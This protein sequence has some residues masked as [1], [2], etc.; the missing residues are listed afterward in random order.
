MRPPRFARRGFTLIEL[1]VVIAIIAVLIG[2][3]LPAVQRAREAA[4]RS[5][6]QNNLKQIGLAL[7]MYHD[8]RG[9]F[10][11]AYLHEPS[12]TKLAARDGILG[13]GL[14]GRLP[15]PPLALL[16]RAGLDWWAQLLTPLEEGTPAPG[17]TGVVPVK[18]DRPPPPPPGDPQ[19]PGWGWCALLLPFVEQ[20]VLADQINFTIPVEAPSSLAARTTP[21]AVY[22]CP[23]DTKAGLFDVLSY[24]QNKVLGRAMT[25]SYTANYGAL[26]LLTAHPDAGTGLMFRNS[27]VR[28]ADVTDG[29]SNTLAVGERPGT[30]TQTPWAGVFSGGSARTTPGAPVYRAII[31]PSPAMAMAR[32]G[33]RPLLDPNSE[34][35]DFF[36]M[37]NRA[38]EFVFA[39]GSV[40]NLPTTT[41]L[42]VL[43]ALATRAGNEAVDSPD[44]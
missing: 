39:D 28:A 35:Y 23:S 1:L 9:S 32:I 40:H 15:L 33:N 36:S 4:N 17:I 38:V 20:S 43:Q 5:K 11:A 6:C 8:T 42:S 22:R 31:E 30:F 34:P 25:T 21:L 13:D 12:K 10:P 29:L 18:Y 37:H 41:S 27:A 7:H 24:T 19:M 16:H 14:A 2:L 26:G 3:L 44:N